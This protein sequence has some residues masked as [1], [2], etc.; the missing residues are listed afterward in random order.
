MERS[1]QRVIFHNSQ[2]YT[3]QLALELFGQHNLHI[4]FNK[5][6]IKLDELI[7]E[8]LIVIIH[9]R[10]RESEHLFLFEKLMELM[11]DEI[12]IFIVELQQ[13]YYEELANILM[14][15]QHCDVES[16]V[17]VVDS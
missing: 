1:L 4:F 12:L 16:V 15:R 13:A 17:V 7:K 8:D 10:L 9:K 14:P 11:E 2:S 6:Y 3:F 5:E